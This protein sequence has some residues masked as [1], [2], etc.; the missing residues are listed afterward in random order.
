MFGLYA[1]GNSN[2]LIK[3]L[4]EAGLVNGG[5]TTSGLAALEPYR[6]KRAVFL[7]AGFGARLRPVSL[8][9]PKP[10]DDWCFTVYKDGLSLM[11]CLVLLMPGEMRCVLLE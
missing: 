8:N 6:V 11:R 1:I 5:I 9:T 3:E 7:A 10:C 2:R 4:T